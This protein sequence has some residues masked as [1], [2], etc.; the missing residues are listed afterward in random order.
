VYPRG[1]AAGPP[2]NSDVLVLSADSWFFFV[3]PAPLADFTHPVEY[4]AV[5]ARAGTVQRWDAGFQPVVN[6]APLWSSSD[7]LFF[8]SEDLTHLDPPDYPPDYEATPTPEVVQE[9]EVPDD[10]DPPDNPN[11]FPAPLGDDTF[12]SLPKIPL[13][14]QP[15][16]GTANSH[17]NNTGADGVFVVF[18]RTGEESHFQ[19]NIARLSNRLLFEGV[20]GSNQAVADFTN[21]APPSIDT[22]GMTGLQVVDAQRAA[23]Q[24]LLR[25]AVLHFEPQIIGRLEEGKHSTLVVYITGHGGGGHMIVD[26]EGDENGSSRPRLAACASSSNRAT[27]RCS[28]TG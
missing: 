4:V 27:P 11:E 21:L 9:A 20:V 28:R 7:E 10:P 14:E 16:T 13:E 15:A 2:Q 24:A 19:R 23:I 1:S 3:N 25:K 5:A 6:H 12:D 22:A 26:F 8:F 17:F 18:I